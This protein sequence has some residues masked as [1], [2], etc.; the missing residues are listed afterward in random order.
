M[1]GSSMDFLCIGAPR[2]GTTWLAAALKAH[3]GAWI[4]PGKELNFFNDCSFASF[5]YKYLRGIDF[6][7]QYFK[8]APHGVKLGELSPQY[9]VDPNVAFR[10][11]K[12]FPNVRL[13][14]ILRNPAEMVF[15][16]YVK[17]RSL[18]RRAPTFEQELERS[19]QL[20]DLGYC[21]RALTP[22][23]DWFDE[24]QI[25]ILLYEELFADKRAG[26]R[27]VFSFIDIDAEFVPPTMDAQINVGRVLDHESFAA[28]RGG[29]MKILNYPSVVPVKRILEWLRV[30][31]MKYEQM[32]SEKL[33]GRRIQ[34]SPEMRAFLL[35][36]YQPEIRRLENLLGRSLDLWRV[37]KTD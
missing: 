19:P 27:D 35:E 3:P 22:Y 11:R 33:K 13:I 23:F 5:E 37:S 21:H 32:T 17:R 26:L 28:L 29:A 9:Y 14:V 34:L 7:R 18:E 12:Y 24:G 20:L 25:K 30:N 10:I 15:S 16:Y 4:P 6:Y 31:R 1:N 2:S 36:R 8:A